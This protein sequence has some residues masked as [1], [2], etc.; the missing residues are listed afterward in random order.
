MNKCKCKICNTEFKTNS[1]GDLTKHISNVHY[2]SMS[3]Y[4]I[5]TEYDNIAPVCE[6]GFCNDIPEFYRGKFKKYTK[7]HTS[8]QWYQNN[9]IRVNGHP[10]CEE[11]GCN[12]S[13]RKGRKVF[14]RFC[15]T[16]CSGTHNKDVI[17]EKMRPKIIKRYATDP[18]YRKKVS[19]AVSNRFNDSEYYNAHIERT[20]KWNQSDRARAIKSVSSKLMWSDD[21]F[22]ERQS[23][24]I[25]HS[26]NLPAEKKRR[27]DQQKA[28][29]KDPIIGPMYYKALMSI[30]KRFSKLHIRI[31]NKLQLDSLGFKGEQKNGRYCVDELHLDKKIIIEV[32]GDYVHANPKFYKSD[33]IIR[34]YGSSYT[35]GE[36]WD[37]DEC[38]IHNLES[39]GYTVF[40]IWENDDLNMIKLKLD[41]LLQ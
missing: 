30:S 27:S 10:T 33:D 28:R 34:L 6:C 14:P 12:V 17:I 5:L 26:T 38:R 32:N 15:S 36:K 21:E 11:C 4:I 2:M 8:V 3:E 9:Y 41:K 24:L 19:I 39:M 20:T 35:A 7:G 13:F 31:R 25:K 18:E 16:K 40:V 37:S 22:R 29:W 23:E 1:G